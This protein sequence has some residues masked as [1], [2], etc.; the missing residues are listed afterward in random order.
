MVLNLAVIRFII[1][2]KQIFG[3]DVMVCAPVGGKPLPTKVLT[4]RGHYPNYG[5]GAYF[6]ATKTPTVVSSSGQVVPGTVFHKSNVDPGYSFTEEAAVSYGSYGATASVNRYGTLTGRLYEII[7]D[8]QAGRLHYQKFK[9]QVAVLPKDNWGG[10]TGAVDWVQKN[11]SRARGIASEA[12]VTQAVVV[13]AS[14]YDADFEFKLE[15]YSAFNSMEDMGVYPHDYAQG[16]AAA[17]VEAS[18]GFAQASTNSIANMLEAIEAVK[19]IADGLRS[20]TNFIKNIVR[21]YKDPRDAWLAYRYVYTTTKLDV[22]E[23]QEFFEQMKLLAKMTKETFNLDGSFTT[24]SGLK[25]HC[26]VVVRTGELI[27]G[28]LQAWLESAGFNP[29]LVN[30]WDMVPYSFVVDWFLH[31]SD[32]L[33]YVQDVGVSLELNPTE[34]WYSVRTAYDG[35]SVYFRVPGR[36]LDTIPYMGN[37][38]ISD[39]TFKMRCADAISLFT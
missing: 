35:Q 25:C 26:R 15:E 38:T 7:Y 22:K 16:L 10:I 31:V 27:P 32:L 17:Y 18:K 3:T 28:S 2:S 9:M 23:Y 36:K 13:N 14:T 1:G 12:S 29:D 24:D 39:R 4:S 34:I 20:P 33:E 19:A 6:K 21:K 8:H 11:A 5:N 30:A 37:I